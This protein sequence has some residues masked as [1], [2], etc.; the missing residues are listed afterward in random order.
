MQ[1]CPP[2]IQLFAKSSDAFRALVDIDKVDQL[3]GSQIETFAQPRPLTPS[4][5]DGIL[6]T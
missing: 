6:L 5:L 2:V 1:R 3:I 4:Q